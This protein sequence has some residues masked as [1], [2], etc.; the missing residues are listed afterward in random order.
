MRRMMVVLLAF[1]TLVALTTGIAAA[2]GRPIVPM[3]MRLS[4]SF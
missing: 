4:R 2:E 1:L 3:P